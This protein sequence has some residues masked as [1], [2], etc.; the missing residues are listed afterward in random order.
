MGRSAGE[1]FR[2]L[3]DTNEVS[4]TV[5]VSECQ[6]VSQGVVVVCVCGV[7]RCG[8]CVAVAL[9]PV[10]LSHRGESA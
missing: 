7:L 5:S 3:L 9:Y 2:I 1:Y 6:S 10:R 4:V 8:A